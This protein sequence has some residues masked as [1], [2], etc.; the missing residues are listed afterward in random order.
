MPT[1]PPSASLAS[2]INFR[3][4]APRLMNF[5][6]IRDFLSKK[7]PEL[8]GRVGPEVFTNRFLESLNDPAF[9]ILA[10][11]GVQELIGSGAKPEELYKPQALTQ[12]YRTMGYK[13]QPIA[14]GAYQKTLGK[15]PPRQILPQMSVADFEAELRR[16]GSLNLPAA[17]KAKQLSDFLS[18]TEQTIGNFTSWVKQNM[19]FIQLGS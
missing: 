14:A 13:D 15:V 4:V 3:A 8:S 10:I 18:K 19:P 17:E 11:S 5:K 7:F 12:Y 16:I 1:P 2:G 9:I 6:P